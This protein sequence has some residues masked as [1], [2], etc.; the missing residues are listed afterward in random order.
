MKSLRVVLA[1]S[2]A[3][4]VSMTW[5]VVPAHADETMAIRKVDT[6]DYPNVSLTV[7]P[8]SAAGPSDKVAL[9]ENGR[10]ITNAS[11][12]KFAD[13]NVPVGIA[14]LIDS[15]EASKDGDALTKQKAAAVEMIRAKQ[16]NEKFAVVAYNTSARPIVNFTDNAQIL[17]DGINALQ[18]SGD[19]ALWDGVNLASALFANEP[20]LQANVVVMNTGVNKVSTAS[21]TTVRSTL[22]SS[23]AVLFPVILQQRQETSGDGLKSLAAE[24]GGR[25]FET[26]DPSTATQVLTGL[27][28]D[29]QDQ[30]LVSYRSPGAK[31]LNIE[32][33]L[34]GAKATAHTSPGTVSEG[35]QVAPVVVAPSKAPSW[36]S[37]LVGILLV[38]LGT[39]VGVA[40]LVYGV[41]EIVGKERNNLVSALRPYS[42]EEP[43]ERDLSKLADTEIIRKAV[44]ET[45]RIAQERGLLQIV[46]QRLEQADLPL[47]P[48]EAIFFTAVAAIVAMIAGLALFGILGLALAGLIFAYMPIAITS[49]KA[50]RRK[51]KFTSQLPDT[52]QLL[53]GSLRA[54]YSLVQGMDAVAKQC[55]APM[56]TELSRAMAEARLGRPVEDALQD[57]SDRM[58]S[59]DFEW[60]VMAIK[61]QRE[62]GGN[63][64]ELLMTVSETMVERERLRREVKALTAEG[65]I[66]AIVLV[67]LPPSIGLLITVMNRTY[68]QPLIGSTIGQL[69]LV[70]AGVMMG[71]GYWMMNKLI[72]IEA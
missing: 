12:K 30:V 67:S 70:V 42:D 45:A 47:K 29:L 41:I 35:S 17:I 36:F 55:E 9:S 5:G 38:A 61:I 50:K 25:V 22:R 51:K 44:A 33:G 54:G 24:T 71:V 46:Q 43:E 1:T 34:G 32:V 66:S 2:V 39:L 64:A 28:S 62:V 58:G 18:P 8:P 14:I 13:A 11:V 57:I 15:T 49:F 20:G 26:T 60:A 4:L 69:A 52:L 59:D 3:A 37:G 27:G 68:M 40:L 31:A 72:Q 10:A 6:S 53:A 23:K 19:S 65:R 7:F 48:A 63:L 56:G 21:L 16:P